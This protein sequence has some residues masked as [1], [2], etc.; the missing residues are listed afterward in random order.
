[1]LNIFS[2]LQQEKVLLAC[3]VGSDLSFPTN[4]NM[5]SIMKNAHIDKSNDII[6]NR[7]LKHFIL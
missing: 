3:D 4:E 1:M 7:A 2:L 6:Q 5:K